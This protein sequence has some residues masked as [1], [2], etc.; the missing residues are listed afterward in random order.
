MNVTNYFN[1]QDVFI[2][3][4]FGDVWL[5]LFVGIILIAVLALRNRVPWQPLALLG[6][7]WGGVV[8]AANTASLEVI[9]ILV[10]LV[11]GGMFYFAISRLINR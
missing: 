1:F 6:V 10:V 11:V 9:W 3:E 4:L 5:F 8:F 7:L 2:G